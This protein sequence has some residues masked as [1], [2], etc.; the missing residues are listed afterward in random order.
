MTNVKRIGQAGVK[1]QITP[2]MVQRATEILW[3]SGA[4]SCEM[5]GADQLVVRKML[6]AALLPKGAQ[7]KRLSRDKG[8]SILGRNTLIF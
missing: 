5:D 1:I 7:K 6:E 3:A 4:V 8:P 2:A